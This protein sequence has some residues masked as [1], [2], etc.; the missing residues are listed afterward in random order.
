MAVL[1][2]VPGLSVT[3]NVAGKQAT[4]YNDP[5]HQ[6]AE[7]PPYPASRCYIE[8]KSAAPFEI[9]TTINSQYRFP[10]R[11]DTIITNVEI[12][13]VHIGGLVSSLIPKRRKPCEVVFEGPYTPSTTPNKLTVKKLVF[14][15]VT[16]GE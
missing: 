12:D 11:R 6:D 13:G 9:V 16:S 14:S 1:P 3:I 2:G 7:N 15:P 5:N 8:S 10:R 4:E